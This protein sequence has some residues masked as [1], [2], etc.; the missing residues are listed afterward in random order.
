VTK[1][2]LMT[3]RGEP[4]DRVPFWFMR[5]AGRYLPEYRA[6]RK[7]RGSFL[8]LV[9]SPEY[10]IEVTL[11]PIRRY[12]M[13]AAILF[14]DILV[15]P[16]A[17]GQQVSFVSGRGPVLDPVRDRRGLGELSTNRLHEKLGPVY[18]TVSGLREQLPDDVALIGFAGAPWTVATYMVEGEGSKD[19]GAAKQW[20]YADE[21]GFKA[22]IDLLVEATSRYLIRQV[23]AGAEVLQIFDTWAGALSE[24]AFDKWCIAPT[25]QIIDNVR[26]ACPDVPILGFPRGAGSLYE[27]YVIETGVDGVSLDTAAELNWAHRHLQDKVVVQGNLDPRLVVAGGDE[28]L[29]EAGRILEAFAGDGASKGHIFNLGHGFVPETPPENVARL[30]EFIKNWKG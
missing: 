10:A 17:L 12:G 3:L 9:Y 4:T 2:L 13:D 29:H 26:G 18:Q 7:D 23:E 6:T 11:Q 5:Q 25:R 8:D 28:M 27:R 20:S 22:L 14:S 30:S 15:I 19:H 1:R 16:D 21:K 24:T